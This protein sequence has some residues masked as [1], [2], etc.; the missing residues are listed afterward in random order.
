MHLIASHPNPSEFQTNP[1]VNIIRKVPSACAAIGN[2][3]RWVLQLCT[4]L[5]ISSVGGL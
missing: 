5:Q 3:R 2:W 4:C 1:V